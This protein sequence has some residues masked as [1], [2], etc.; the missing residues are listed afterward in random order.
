MKLVPLLPLSNLRLW[1]QPLIT[2]AWFLL[3][4][5]VLCLGAPLLVFLYHHG[6]ISGAHTWLGA[7]AIMGIMLCVG[8]STMRKVLRQD[9]AAREK[10]FLQTNKEPRAKRV[11]LNQPPTRG[12]SPAPKGGGAIELVPVCL[13]IG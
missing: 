11:V 10:Y 9:K 5:G 7:G 4:F 2:L 3:F 13:F 6:I 8:L 1:R 12:Q